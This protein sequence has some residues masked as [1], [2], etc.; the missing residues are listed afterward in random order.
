MLHYP[1][2]HFYKKILFITTL[3]LILFF[4]FLWACKHDPFVPKHSVCYSTEIKNIFL[5]NCTAG[6]CHNASHAAGGYDFT[7]Y[8]GISHGLTPGK[9]KESRIIDV[10][11]GT[12]SNHTGLN[13]TAYDRGLIKMWIEQGAMNDITCSPDYCDSLTISYNKQ[14]KK[15]LNTYCVSCHKPGGAGYLYQY[16]DTITNIDKT[17][18]V[19]FSTFQA[20]HKYVTQRKSDF[21][22]ILGFLY[23]DNH[24]GITLT[25]KCDSTIMT[26]WALHGGN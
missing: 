19:D 3:V 22:K 25:S 12:R 24:Q 9:P 17:D 7:T 18:T 14:A 16:T 8:E 26:R 13:L 15:F 20:S 23:T 5:A 21:L 11:Y 10:I 6:N 2:V 1:T 4:Q